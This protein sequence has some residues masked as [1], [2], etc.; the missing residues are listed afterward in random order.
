MCVLIYRI[1][2]LIWSLYKVAF[3]ATLT[4]AI[5][6]LWDIYALCIRWHYSELPISIRVTFKFAVNVMGQSDLVGLCCQDEKTRVTYKTIFDE[7]ADVLPGVS[8]GNFV[9]FIGI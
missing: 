3:V 1:F 9:Y 4:T 7:L 2:G 8:V 5:L 6:D